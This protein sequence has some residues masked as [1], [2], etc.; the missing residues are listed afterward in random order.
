M[1]EEGGRQEGGRR[2]RLKRPN[3]MISVCARAYKQVD[4]RSGRKCNRAKFAEVKD[5]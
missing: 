4:T 2:E 3:D 1:A 5:Y